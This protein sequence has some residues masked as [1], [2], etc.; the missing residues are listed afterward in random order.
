MDAAS[1]G[2]CSGAGY[3]GCGCMAGASAGVRIIVPAR[4][5]RDGFIAKAHSVFGNL[6][7][8]SEVEYV[9]SM[10]PVV[11]MCKRHS[12]KFDQIPNLHLQGQTRCKACQQEKFRK[13]RGFDREGFIAKA[14]KQFGSRYDYSQVVYKDSQSPVTI[15][16]RKHHREFQQKPASHL[17][18]NK[19]CRDCHREGPGAAPPV[20]REE[21]I[22]RAN[23]AHGG[24]YDYSRIKFRNMLA[25]VEIYCA[26]HNQ[27]FP[28]TPK[29][30]LRGQACRQCYQERNRDERGLGLE[31]W[32]ERA[33]AKHGDRFDYSRATYLSQN[34]PMEVICRKHA[35]HGPFLVTPYQHPRLK[36]GGCPYC[37]PVLNTQL[38][39]ARC[40]EI[41]PDHYD[42]S[43]AKFTGYHGRVTIRCTKHNHTFKP[44]AVDLIQGRGCRHCGLERTRASLY[45]NTEEFIARCQKIHRD[46]YGYDRAEYVGVFDKAQVECPIHGYFLIRCADHL[47]GGGCPDC[48]AVSKAVRFGKDKWINHPE[49]AAAEGLLY[50][51]RIVTPD[52]RTLFKIGVTKSTV[53]IRYREHRGKA[54]P[55]G[56]ET[57]GEWST[58]MA[59]AVSVERQILKEHKAS[60]AKGEKILLGGNTELF[61]EDALGLTGA[62]ASKMKRR[63]RQALRA[64]E[65]KW[66]E[67]LGWN[68]P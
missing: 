60:R 31:K 15:I 67:V 53:K 64:S 28:V 50:Y 39:L 1:R 23:A 45:S 58:L 40:K 29:A 63:I 66:A 44:K 62:D 46:F 37:G 49:V 68:E 42:F 52:N 8:Y 5:T 25:T 59:A 22:E 20:T 33:Q 17:I 13:A 2:R 47:K 48:A 11:V 9:N 30:H 19:G 34:E 35:A 21:F 7:D 16:C 26:T 18:G 51:L 55:L 32:I 3:V 54:H 57:L 56:I 6:Y 27:L 65:K 36:D 10:T 43:K 14:K 61:I 4:D 24:R 12:N 41:H 38:L